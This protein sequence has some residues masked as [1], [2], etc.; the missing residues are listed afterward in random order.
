M[1]F[2]YSKGGYKFKSTFY[3]NSFKGFFNLKYNTCGSTK[4]RTFLLNKIQNMTY[5]TIQNSNYLKNGIGFLLNNSLVNSSL[6]TTTQINSDFLTLL[7][8]MNKKIEDILDNG[9]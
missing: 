8:E 6:S 7:I 1:N 2:N 5:V 3:K 4:Y 9:L